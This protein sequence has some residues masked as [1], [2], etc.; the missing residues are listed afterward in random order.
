MLNEY[1][2]K[3]V[4]NGSLVFVDAEG[5][6]GHILSGASKFIM[7]KIP[8]CLEFWPY[9]LKNLNSFE[10]LKQSLI[11]AL[12]ERIYDLKDSENCLTFSLENIEKLAL[13]YSSEKE[14]TD[15]LIC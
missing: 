2:S 9:A 6:E 13:K 3:N 4:K 5:F 11:N 12:Y 10:L 15:L 8:I 1:F 14:L 7:A